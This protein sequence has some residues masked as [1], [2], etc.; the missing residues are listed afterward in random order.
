MIGAAVWLCFCAALLLVGLLRVRE[1]PNM[2]SAKFSDFLTP[3]PS[4]P[5]F[6]SDLLYKIHV[7]SLTMS[8]FP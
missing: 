5:A 6:G 7:T 2:L 3:C 4:L 1:L 8:A